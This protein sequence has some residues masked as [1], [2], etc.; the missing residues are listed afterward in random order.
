MRI[1]LVPFIVATMLTGIS[2]TKIEAQ[3]SAATPAAADK[4]KTK[5]VYRGANRPIMN[6]YTT[7]HVKAQDRGKPSLKGLPH[8]R[9]FDQ[10]PRKLKNKALIARLKKSD[11][12]LR[13]RINPPPPKPKTVKVGGYSLSPEQQKGVR[14]IVKVYR[15]HGLNPAGGIAVAIR[16]SNIRTSARGDLD[17]GWYCSRGIFQINFCAR[18]TGGRY[19][20]HNRHSIEARDKGNTIAWN[21]AY[22]ARHTRRCPN[23]NPKSATSVAYVQTVCFELPEDK[24]TKARED[25]RRVPLARQIVAWADRTRR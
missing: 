14:A 6:R 19:G 9:W 10:N 7:M 3:A 18:M 1:A 12:I 15:A 4:K 5:I 20:S 16:E 17:G 23:L 21:V 11:R 8:P 2:V 24:Y 25:V 22:A 13:H